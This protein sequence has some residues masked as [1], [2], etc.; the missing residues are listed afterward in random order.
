MYYE[1]SKDRKDDFQP[2]L[3]KSLGDGHLS[4]MHHVAGILTD[5]GG[6]GGVIGENRCVQ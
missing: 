1:G 2:E 3:R 4:L 5:T 6:G